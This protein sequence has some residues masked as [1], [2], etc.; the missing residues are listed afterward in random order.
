MAG[1]PNDVASVPLMQGPQNTLSGPTNGGA[2][3]AEP[4]IPASDFEG[5][6][7]GGV[8]N[9]G[10]RSIGGAVTVPLVKDKMLLRIEGYET[11]TDAR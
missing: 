6:I 8:G 10:R 7:E 9:Y 11:H 1:R 3:V 2:T 5:F 4:K